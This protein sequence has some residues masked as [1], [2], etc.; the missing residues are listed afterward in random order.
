MDYDKYLDEQ[1][2]DLKIN[3]VAHDKSAH[4]LPATI[5]VNLPKM[6]KDKGQT[7]LDLGNYIYRRFGLR[8]QM[9]PEYRGK[10]K[11][12]TIRWFMS[13]ADIEPIRANILKACG[14]PEPMLRHEHYLPFEFNSLIIQDTSRG[15]YPRQQESA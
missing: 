3:L 10:G 6:P 7:A 2:K 5:V 4:G 11:N 1:F 14:K 12:T 13:W 9:V 15:V 8:Y